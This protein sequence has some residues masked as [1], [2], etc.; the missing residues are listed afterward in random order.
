MF[1]LI[2]NLLFSVHSGGDSGNLV[3][4]II[5]AV[6]TMTDTLLHSSPSEIFAGLLP[7]I[8]AMENIHP[9]LVHFP[10]AFLSAFFLIDLIACILHKSDWRRTAD[11]FLYIGTVFAGFTMLAGLSAAES[12]AH[13]EN[14]HQIME[15]H[16]HLGISIFSL[17]TFLSLWRLVGKS[18]LRGATNYLYLSLAGL[19]SLLLV[20]A[21]DLGGLMV[22]K[23]GVAV[24]TASSLNHEGSSEHHHQ[25][26]E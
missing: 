2:G 15:D 11:W 3:I 14:V 6:L 17:A 16:E 23:H 5:G 4:D 12:V 20:F 13:S 8:A 18:G 22:Y 25:H 9:L 10:I 24:A 19:L 26:S 7:G 1:D 21:A